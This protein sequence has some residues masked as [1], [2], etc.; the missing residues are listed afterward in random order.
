MLLLLRFWC[1]P[2][3]ETM[4]VILLPVLPRSNEMDYWNRT[5]W[6]KYQGITIIIKLSNALHIMGYLKLRHNSWIVYDPFY[7]ECVWTDFCEVTVEAIPPDAP[8]PKGEDVDLCKFVDSNQPGNKINRSRTRFMIYMNMSLINRYSKKQST[9]ET[10][11][12]LQSLLPWKS[13]WKPWVLSNIS[14][15]WWAFQYL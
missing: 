10:S 8:P 3:I 11:E 15:G 6:Y 14:W 2:R 5:N 4:W 7:P 12:F 13:A 1:V 9:I